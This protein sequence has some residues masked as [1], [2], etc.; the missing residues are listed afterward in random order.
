MEGVIHNQDLKGIMPHS[1]DYIFNA[2]RELYF[3]ACATSLQ[4]LFTMHPFLFAV[5]C[6]WQVQAA[7]ENVEFLVRASFLEIYMDEVYDLLNNSEKRRRMVRNAQRVSS[8]RALLVC[9]LFP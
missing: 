9:F 7:P 6:I 2:V 8:P 3:G 5:P 4:S 1:F